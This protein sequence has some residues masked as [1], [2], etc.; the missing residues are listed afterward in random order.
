MNIDREMIK[1]LETLA[2]IELR[3]ADIGPMTEQLERI[4]AFVAKLQAVDTSSIAPTKLAIR[5]GDEHLR[6]DT[7]EPGLKR[8]AVLKQ[9]PD[10]KDGLF[11]VPRVIERGE[12]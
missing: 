8:N 10:A 7:V 6:A 12:T 3:P 11:R 9:A 1:H 5:S 4:V 2:R